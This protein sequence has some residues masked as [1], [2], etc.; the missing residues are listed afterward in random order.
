MACRVIIP[1]VVL[2][3]VF[4]SVYDDAILVVVSDAEERRVVQVPLRV[5]WVLWHWDV[6]FVHW[7]D[8]GSH[9]VFCL[10]GHINSP[11]HFSFRILL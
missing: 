7:V 9:S 2:Y 6:D 1:I 4:A 10:F 11:N 5:V 3:L 8:V